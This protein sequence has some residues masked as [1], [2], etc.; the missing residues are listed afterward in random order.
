MLIK[1]SRKI[2]VL[3]ILV[4]ITLT[5]ILALAVPWEKNL[6]VS[7]IESNIDLSELVDRDSSGLFFAKTPQ[8][9]QFDL[10][11][12]AYGNNILEM[13]GESF[14]EKT[15]KY[16]KSMRQ[17]DG[18]LKAPGINI[19]NPIENIYYSVLAL[20]KER[21]NDLSIKETILR[22]REPDGSFYFAVGNVKDERVLLHI[23]LVQTKM[24]VF[25]LKRTCGDLVDLGSTSKWLFSLIDNDEIRGQPALL[26]VVIKTLSEID[27][28]NVKG[29]NLGSVNFPLVIDSF[30]NN[31]FPSVVDIS[32]LEGVMEINSL[33]LI[34]L[35]DT[36]KIK[37]QNK[38]IELL[39]FEFSD[40]QTVCQLVNI[41]LKAGGDKQNSEL[42]KVASNIKARELPQGGLALNEQRIGTPQETFMVLRILQLSNNFKKDPMVI[43][44]LRTMLVDYLEDRTHFD[45]S[46]LF[47]LLSVLKLEKEE[48]T[49]EQK[50]RLIEI[51][52]P[53]LKFNLSIDNIQEWYYAV[54]MLE[55]LGYKFDSNRDLPNNFEQ[56]L[57]K[58]SDEG[59]IN[60]GANNDEVLT[61]IFVDG[62][63]TISPGNAKLNIFKRPLTKLC[64]TGEEDNFVLY[65]RY[66]AS[67]ALA[68]LEKLPENIDETIELLRLLRY[69]GGFKR[70]PSA[71][72]AD[73]KS[74]FAAVN[75][76]YYKKQKG[77]DCYR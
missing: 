14:S 76:L 20:G 3:S 18:T 5:T 52:K 23:K 26:G 25:V 75:L 33:G 66:Y 71:T 28:N 7:S 48:I 60:F 59:F 2:I 31:N 6:S 21:P 1:A 27:P 56:I 9:N 13:I 30:V 24:A 69:K 36:D 41:F 39:K 50:N 65:K 19:D 38:C 43:N 70:H 37:I 35:A 64:S 51:V 67:I 46:Q 63:S 57:T 62:I 42:K 22:Y 53:Q 49:Q 10:Y 32:N 54:R 34:K 72:Y 40:E 12:T 44:T 17:K 16:L 15:Y 77:V 4:L 47:S 11:T 55:L 29:L 8:S 68:R 74:T 73:L 45:N 61:A 58:R